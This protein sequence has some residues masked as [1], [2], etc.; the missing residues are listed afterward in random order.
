VAAKQ[1]CIVEYLGEVLARH[2]QYCAGRRGN[3]RISPGIRW[4][5]W[6]V[7]LTANRRCTSTKLR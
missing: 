7:A 5:V 6:W 1:A 2:E 3:K 4:G